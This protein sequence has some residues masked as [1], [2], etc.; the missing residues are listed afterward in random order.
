LRSPVLE[1]QEVDE[2]PV[3]LERVPVLRWLQRSV[4]AQ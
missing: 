2:A 3:D 4:G 1:G